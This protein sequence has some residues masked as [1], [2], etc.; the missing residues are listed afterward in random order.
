MYVTMY[1]E[2]L[3]TFVKVIST[4]MIALTGYALV[5]FILLKE[6]GNF[7]DF[8]FSTAKILVMMVGELDYTDILV[9]HVV[10]NQTVPGT[11]F[12]YVPLPRLTFA[13]F[14]VFILMVSIVLV[15]LLVGLAVGDI[16]SIQ[17]TASLRALI[18]QVFLVD[19]IMKSYP[20]WILR[21]IHKSS[22]EIKPNQNSF[23]KR[24]LL[25]GSDLSAREFMELLLSRK[26]G[27]TTPAEEWRQ[28]ELARDETQG[29]SI[30]NLQATVEAQGR[31][32]QAMADRLRILE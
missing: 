30:R 31:L 32:L 27:S 4:F 6:Q 23:L 11:S 7:S 10:N 25:A 16:E 2:V 14:L 28:I 8:W 29:E 21:R 22:L 17:R 5:F 20:S 15:N 3:F 13:L 1:V 24:V 19:T 18:D 26:S 9:E 12:P